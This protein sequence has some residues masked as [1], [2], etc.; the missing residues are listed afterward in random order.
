MEKEH[1]IYGRTWLRERTSFFCRETARSIAFGVVMFLSFLLLAPVIMLMAD[2]LSTSNALIES[3]STISV[4]S[5][6]LLLVICVPLCIL[7]WWG[8]LEIAD[9]SRWEKPVPT[10]WE[11]QKVRMLESTLHLAKRLESQGKKIDMSI[12]LSDDIYG[13]AHKFIEETDEAT[14][15]LYMTA[16]LSTKSMIN[17]PREY[18]EAKVNPV[19]QQLVD[20][21][22]NTG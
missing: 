1:V 13:E 5:F 21:K 2:A 15:R 6:I 7:C 12:V 10:I 17:N 9:D 11:K 20:K 8:A 16:L 19:F 14:L 3:E 4:F 22:E 18:V